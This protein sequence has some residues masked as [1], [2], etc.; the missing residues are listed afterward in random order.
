MLISSQQR[1]NWARM[2][3][4]NHPFYQ[5][6]L[7]NA[8]GAMYADVGRWPSLAYT[9][10]S[11]AKYVPI[12]YKVW[13]AQWP[14]V[15]SNADSVREFTIDYGVIYEMLKPGLSVTE[16]SEARAE[17]ISIADKIVKGTLTGDSDQVVGSFL[18]LLA[19]DAVLGTSYGSGNFMDGVGGPTKPVGGFVSTG[20]NRATM[21]N[22]IS[23]YVKMSEGGVWPEGIMYNANTLGLLFRGCQFITNHTG[24]DH[25]P[26]VTAF[27]N[28]Y[29]RVMMREFIPNLKEQFQ[30]GDIQ[31]PHGIEWAVT[32]DIFSVVSGLETGEIADGLRQFEAD[33]YTANNV[34]LQAAG[35]PLYARYMWFVN[36][37]GDKQPWEPLVEESI[38]ARGVGQVYCCHQ[39]RGFQFQSADF[40][41]GIV[42]HWQGITCGDVRLTRKGRW[43][44]DHP[45]SYAADYRFYNLSLI[46][47][48]GPNGLEAGG[49]V[50]YA[51]EDGKFTYASGLACGLG[52]D[53]S[54]GYYNPPPT[55]C[56]ENGR[57]PFWLC[58]EDEDILI[59]HD[60]RHA[61]D[62]RNQKMANGS[63]AIDRYY[64]I[65]KNSIT[66]A[67]GVKATLWHT[68]TAPIVSSDKKELQWMAGDTVVKL[69]QIFPTTSP[70]LV[71][72]DEKTGIRDDTG[73]ALVPALGGNMFPEQKKFL[74]YS[75][76]GGEGFDTV[77]TVLTIAEGTQAEGNVYVPLDAGDVQGVTVVRPG[78]PDVLVLFSKK[79]GPK[80]T[81][82]LDSKGVLVNDRA[83]F[84]IVKAAR[85]VTILPEFVV[86]PG[87][88]LYFADLDPSVTTVNVNGKSEPLT[89][90]GDIAVA[91]PEVPT[92]VPDE[93]WVI[94]EQDKMRIVL[95]LK[96]E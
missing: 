37:F 65:P 53:I 7:S 42:D 79:P 25:F 6:I 39:D 64:P 35:V 71:T 55:Y 18:G 72:V 36:P 87:A 58:D 32:P 85:L 16:E 93:K 78:K 21:R 49:I 27:R 43:P 20:A 41:N 44:L 83:K 74:T 51:H 81:N 2:K 46:A 48:R 34:K 1:A 45:L 56:H 82:T 95:E 22:C 8:V 47:N 67:L 15:G 3:S 77:L 73:E 19:I 91:K 84:D 59:I 69:Q 57:S 31:K 62:P 9:I 80:L 33:V 29:A 70:T 14:Y 54:S 96:K 60:R 61:D 10:T 63:P 40:R 75:I 92:P 88:T 66:N 30:W 52:P 24:V 28:A 89:R 12:A 4:E 26:E 90:I 23:Q 17:L 50:G 5:I 86:N 94:T 11:D 68:P 13:K 38:V 76:N